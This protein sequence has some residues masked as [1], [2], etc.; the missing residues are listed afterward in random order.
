MAL[1]L[2]CGIASLSFLDRLFALIFYLCRINLNRASDVSKFIFLVPFD[3]ALY[4][5]SNNFESV[6]GRIFFIF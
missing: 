2:V 3:F 6:E 4:V 5:S 1:V